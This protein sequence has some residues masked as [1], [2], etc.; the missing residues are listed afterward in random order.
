VIVLS[1]FVMSISTR[2]HARAE[3]AL[4]CGHT[5]LPHLAFWAID[6]RL[7]LRHENGADISAPLSGMNQDRYI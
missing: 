1:L 4:V 5:T 3:L 7:K 6:D 2:A